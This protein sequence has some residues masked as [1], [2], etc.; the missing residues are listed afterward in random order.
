MSLAEV[1]ESTKP[2]S[3]GALIVR[4]LLWLLGVLVVAAAVDR[5]KNE[6]GLRVDLGW[7]FFFLFTAGILSYFLFGFIPTF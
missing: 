3:P 1:I 5:N 6:R 7:F 4:G 2:G